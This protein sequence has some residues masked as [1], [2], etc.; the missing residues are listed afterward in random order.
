M[1][2]QAAPRPSPRP[3]YWP[4]LVEWLRTF[5]GA[6][7]RAIFLVGGVV[8]DA[9][10][11]YPAHD[12][13]LAV[14][15]D[16]FRVARQI[17]DALGGAFYKLD[18]VRETGRAIV[19]Y[20]G[21]QLV[22]DVAVLR[23]GDLQADLAG[24]DFTINAVAAPLTG[25]PDAVLDPLDGLSDAQARILRRCSEQAIASDPIRALRAVRMSTRF[26]L[27]IEP[28]TLADI[29][30]HG[31]RLVDTS[32]ERIR[33]EF[34]GLLA[35]TRPA[36]ALRALDTLGLLRLIIPEIEGMRGV[37]LALPHPSDLWQ[38]ALATVEQLDNI[39]H[40]IS[41]Q[42]TDSSAAQA[43]LGMIVYYLDRFRPQLQAHLAHQWP[44]QRAH[45]ALLLLAAL[46]HDSG[47]RAIQQD[48]ED[49]L[50]FTGHAEAGAVLAQARGTALML[51]KPEVTRLTAIVRHHLRPQ[52]HFQ[53][54]ELSRR[55][56]YRF[57][58]DCDVAGVD[59]CLLAMADTLATTGPMLSPDEWGR[60]L[61]DIGTLL[62]GIYG[63]GE[64]NVTTLPT[65]VSGTDLIHALGLRPGPQ[66]GDLLAHIRE[67][68][69]AGEISTSEDALALARK[70]LE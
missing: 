26:R 31:P 12:I 47:K 67:A 62:A 63:E 64:T 23:G 13:D 14:A 20:E 51:S 29:K 42:R 9:F 19:E 24:R 52:R 46:L 7:E 69:A 11:G 57:W 54:A 35:G 2:S 4:P 68:Q 36:A 30:T 33:D 61:S 43:G 45:R 37:R 44:N 58:R 5:F 50:R 6:D 66:I 59:V 17:A 38:H 15:Q 53:K 16:A 18:P 48:E 60:Y 55:E 21:K 27:R 8:R 56:V 40:T 70:L 65:L 39:L 49:H 25:N 22:V 1:S 32:P 28:T 3:L 10:W 41:P 34:I